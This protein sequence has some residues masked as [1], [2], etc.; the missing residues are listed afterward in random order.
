MDH[1]ASHQE[2]GQFAIDTY[3]YDVSKKTQVSDPGSIGPLFIMSLLDMISQYMINAVSIE[4]LTICT[5][6]SLYGNVQIYK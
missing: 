5:S 3:R 4:I 2:R 6:F 1:K